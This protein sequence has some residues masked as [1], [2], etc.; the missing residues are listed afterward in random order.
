M[1]TAVDICNVAQILL[2]AEM[3]A[4]IDAPVS[5][6]E[7]RYAKMYPLVRD[8]ELRKH[9]WNFSKR[10]IVLTPTGAPIEA[11]RERYY[12]YQ[13]PETCLHPVRESHSRWV[14]SGKGQVLWEDNGELKIWIVERVLEAYFDP[15]FASMVAC[16]LAERLCEAITQ[17]NEKKAV[18]LEQYKADRD[19]ARIANA[20]EVG[21]ENIADDDSR[22]SWVQSRYA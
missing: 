16:K 11:D 6:N 20:F 5:T 10:L 4:S 3:L 8:G 2:G 9:R 7:K 19:A 12:R 22:F 21:P 1:Q 18:A 14:P 17:S 13:L 15:L